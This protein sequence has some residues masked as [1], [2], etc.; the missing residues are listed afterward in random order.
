VANTRKMVRLSLHEVDKGITIILN[1]TDCVLTRHDVSCIN[2]TTQTIT[3]N[4]LLTF[5]KSPSVIMKV[6]TEGTEVNVFTDDSANL[7]FSKIDVILV[8]MEFSYYT[9]YFTKDE[10]KR[11]SVDKMLEFFY[12]R[13]YYPLMP[14]FRTKL[15]NSTRAWLQWP[16]DVVWVRNKSMEDV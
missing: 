7:F 6:D 2:E 1:N 10:Q 4:D 3:L 14:D 8:Y 13:D 12:S 15:T 5:V 16:E 9:I 11:K